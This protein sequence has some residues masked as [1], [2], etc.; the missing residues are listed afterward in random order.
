[1]LQQTTARRYSCNP[2]VKQPLRFVRYGRSRDRIEVWTPL[3][4]RAVLLLETVPPEVLL[5]ASGKPARDDRGHYTVSGGMPCQRRP[6]DWPERAEALLLEYRSKAAV[7]RLCKAWHREDEPFRRFL[8]AVESF[9]RDAGIADAERTYLRIA[10]AR[11]IAKR[12]VPNSD[13]HRNRREAQRRQC[14]GPRYHEIAKILAARLDAYPA[15][16]GLADVAF[17]QAAIDAVECTDSVPE[18][19]QIPGH[20]AHKIG[21]AR[22]ASVHE[23]VEDG[24]ITSADVL[25]NVLPQMTSAIRASSIVSEELRRVYVQIYRAFRRRRSLLLLNLE[26][27]VKLEELP[28]VRAVTGTGRHSFG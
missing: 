27:Q 11:F 9:A 18:G 19:T 13:A 21:R 22:I 5:D 12:G 2:L 25:A 10:L 6:S 14:G 3:Y 4:D 24:Y 17:G 1:M 26:T 16:D 15:R 20:L 7:H 28:W 8:K 23:L